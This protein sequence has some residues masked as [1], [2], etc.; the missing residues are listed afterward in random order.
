MKAI[1]T[2]LLLMLLWSCSS[3]SEIKEL[4]LKILS[5]EEIQMQAA[6]QELTLMMWQGDP[7]IN[8]YMSDY[9]VPKVKELHNIDLNI[10]NGQG[11]QVV[12][13]LLAEMD[14]GNNTSKVDMCWINGETFFQL[15]Q[16][17]A[18]YGPFVEHLP[19][20]KYID[21][22]NPFIKYDFQQEVG[23]FEC[24]W[25]NVQM[26]VIYNSAK[27]PSPPMTLEELERWVKQNPGKFTFSADFTGMTLLKSWLIE[28]A[29]GQEA[30]KGEFN[31]KLYQEASQKL[32]S[33]INRIK[34][35][36][37]NNGQSFPSS[38][39][40]MHQL[41]AAGELWFTMSNNDG[42]VDNKILQGLFNEQTRAYVP[43]TGSIQNSHYMG[44]V[45]HSGNKQ[46]ALVVCNFLISKDAQWQKMH[47][48]IWGDGTVLA[49][50]KLS[51]DWQ[52]KFANIPGREY[53]PKRISIQERAL[54][55]PAPEYMLRIF[56]D[57]RAK[58]VIN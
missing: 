11:N 55:E 30:I 3:P 48:D 28:F 9:V 56:E 40:Q 27:V 23:G 22:E 1:Y 13:M 31:E 43:Q 35:Y 25:G 17:N 50:D 58:V 18:L 52:E 15:R 10:V 41:F 26:A 46:A 39:G 29:G 14:A 53:A 47:P 5:W 19:N 45:K 38:T 49:I 16:I 51:I 37:W 21:W 24:P 12:S 2:L 4:D 33:Y 32:W 44:I 42:E 34:P 54:M 36:F 20:S 7:F 57:F 6:T 8:Q